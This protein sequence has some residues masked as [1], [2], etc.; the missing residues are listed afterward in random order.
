MVRHSRKATFLITA[1]ANYGSRLTVRQPVLFCFKD[2]MR[3]DA[4]DVVGWFIRRK[5]KVIMLSGDRKDVVEEAAEELGLSRYKHSC[6]PQD[7][8]EIIERMKG[9]WR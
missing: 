6:K 4:H 8:I 7:K 9:Q 2:R 5:M 3:S 1:I